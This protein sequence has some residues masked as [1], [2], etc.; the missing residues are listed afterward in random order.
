MIC[1]LTAGF[2][3]LQCFS[4]CLVVEYS[5]CFIS[6][7]DL[8]WYVSCLM[9]WWVRSPSCGPNNLHLYDPQQ[10]PGRGVWSRKTGLSSRVIYYWPFQGGA[11]VVI[12]YNC[13]CSSAF[14]LLLT[15]CS[16]YLGY[17]CVHLL[18]KSCPLCFSLV[19]IL[20]YAVLL[21]LFL[22]RLA[23]RAGCGIRFYRFLIIAFSYTF[24][25]RNRLW[26]YI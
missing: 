8:D 17:S 2:L 14:Y 21:Y 18:G 4:V 16:F 26:T 24:R 12:Y 9:H 1:L 7:L 22:P 10:N 11:S 23:F 25:I 13:Q 3:L 15:Y 6:A 20:F 5:S 19:L